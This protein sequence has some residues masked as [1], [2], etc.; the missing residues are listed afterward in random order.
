MFENKQYGVF[1]SEIFSNLD[2]P[3]IFEKKV[4]SKLYLTRQSAVPSTSSLLK[5]T[6]FEFQLYFKF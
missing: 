1:F 6:V 3:E 2:I 5:G 4:N